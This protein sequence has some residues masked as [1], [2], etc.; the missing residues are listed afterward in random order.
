MNRVAASSTEH[1]LSQSE[2][3]GSIFSQCHVLIAWKI[4]N[5][6]GFRNGQSPGNMLRWP[7]SN[8]AVIL[9]FVFPTGDMEQYMVYTYLESYHIPSAGGQVV[10]ESYLPHQEHVAW[11]GQMAPSSYKR[12]SGTPRSLWQMLETST[13]RGIRESNKPMMS[14]RYLGFTFASSISDCLQMIID[15]SQFLLHHPPGE[16]VSVAYTILSDAILYTAFAV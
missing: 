6:P 14:R 12:A 9:E 10:P 8:L 16:V 15:T 7:M 13:S 2:P 3:T 11:D 4:S 1:R 5:I